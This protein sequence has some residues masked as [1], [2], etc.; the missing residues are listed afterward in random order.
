MS[1]ESS[2]LSI[3]SR[4][5]KTED[6]LGSVRRPAGIRGPVVDRGMGQ[7]R[8]SCPIGVDRPQGAANAG[9]AAT[10]EH[11]LRAIG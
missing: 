7:F 11:E 3:R 5:A 8:E 1:V 10:D 9:A 4:F 2:T 6:D